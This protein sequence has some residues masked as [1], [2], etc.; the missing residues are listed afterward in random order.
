MISA[1][2]SFLGGSVFRMIFGEISSF[3]T[4][5]QDHAQEM[6][7]LRLQA[8]LDDK[9]HQR[10]L[11]NLRLQAEL[12]V[13][14]VEALRDSEVS[15]AEAQAF[16]YAMKDAFKPTGIFFVDAWNGVIR[17]AAATLVL[18]L[19]FLKLWKQRFVMDSFDTELA[20]VI[21][22]FFFAS[23]MMDKRGK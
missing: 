17:P 8:E 19:W 7:R 13:R 5:K 10:S 1:L 2:L 3:L 21:L 15:Q 16:G 23:R 11:E 18:G 20:G 14:Q 6:E 22:G 12:G 9:N 4:K